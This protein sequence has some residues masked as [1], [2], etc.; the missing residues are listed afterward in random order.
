MKP[1][2]PMCVLACACACVYTCVFFVSK[3]NLNIFYLT[4]MQLVL[5]GVWRSQKYFIL[6]KALFLVLYSL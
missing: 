4:S 2:T 5:S 1:G 3:D 6:I